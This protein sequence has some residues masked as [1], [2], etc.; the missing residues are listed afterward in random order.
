MPSET[1]NESQRAA[2][3]VEA[4]PYIRALSGKVA[5]VKYRGEEAGAEAVALDIALLQQ[6]GMRPLL[7]HDFG[8][9][10]PRWRERVAA[11]NGEL[12]EAI[13]RYGGRAVGLGGKGGKGVGMTGAGDAGAAGES[14]LDA[15]LLTL[16]LQNGF[17]P[18]VMPAGTGAEVCRLDADRLAAR[19]ACAVEAWTLVMI[20]AAGDWEEGG[21]LATVGEMTTRLRGGELPAASGAMLDA[22]LY[23]L[24]RKVPTAHI[25]DGSRPHALVLELLS[26]EG[27]GTTVRPGDGPH[28]VADCARYFQ[29]AEHW[30]R[31]DLVVGRKQVVRF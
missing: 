2:V 25:V 21:I 26:E 9:E 17:V 20:T 8:D 3:L 22:V 4:L 19:V 11:A 13:N 1:I 10:T 31:P 18:V 27:V 14:E 30:I 29:D 6:L 15:S 24:R 28:F 23:A 7:I 5:V 12:V 16:L